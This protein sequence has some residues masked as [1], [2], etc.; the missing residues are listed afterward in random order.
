MECL[1]CFS[2]KQ[3]RQEQIEEYISDSSSFS[4]VSSDEVKING[5]QNTE[6]KEAKLAFSQKKLSWAILTKMPNQ[7]KLVI[8]LTPESSSHDTV[9]YAVIIDNQTVTVEI[10][11]KLHNDIMEA[12]V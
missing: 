10:P 5:V 6:L 4:P 11:A 9:T 12:R 2:R 1:G 8:P 7:E 3:V